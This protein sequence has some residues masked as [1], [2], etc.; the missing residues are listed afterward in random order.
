MKIHKIAM[1]RGSRSWMVLIEGFLPSWDIGR[2][3]LNTRVPSR[4][5]PEKGYDKRSLKTLASR[6]RPIPGFGMFA[7]HGRGEFERAWTCSRETGLHSR[8]P[9]SRLDEISLFKTTIDSLHSFLDEPE[10]R[11]C[12]GIREGNYLASSASVIWHETDREEPGEYTYASCPETASPEIC[13]TWGVQR[14]IA[15]L[16]K[17]ENGDRRVLWVKDGDLLA[18]C[19][20]AKREYAKVLL[21]RLPGEPTEGVGISLSPLVE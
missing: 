14:R 7:C 15:L 3:K 16:S 4:R 2:W 19:G 12:F 8:V 9:A 5:F 6:T 13:F 18:L 11:D 1:G 17:T 10:H 20:E 21:P